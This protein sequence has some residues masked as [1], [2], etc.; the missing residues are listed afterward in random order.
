MI[1]RRKEVKGKDLRFTTAD[2]KFKSEPG[3][4]KAFVGANSADAL[5]KEF[6]LVE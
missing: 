5:E 1:T 3:K 4:F 2:M 6:E